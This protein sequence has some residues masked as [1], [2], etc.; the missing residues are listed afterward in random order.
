MTVALVDPGTAAQRSADGERSRART[1]TVNLATDGSGAVTST[2]A[3]VV[4]ALNGH[5]ARLGCS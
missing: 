3:Q 4:A 1:I 2:A 5:A